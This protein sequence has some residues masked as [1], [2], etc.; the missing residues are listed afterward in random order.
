MKLVVRLTPLEQ[1]ALLGVL[2][3]YQREDPTEWLDVLNGKVTTVSQLIALVIQAEVT[4][5]EGCDGQRSACG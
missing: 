1:S 2:L 4:V 5:D 3:D